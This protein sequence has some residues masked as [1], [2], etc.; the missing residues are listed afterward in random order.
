MPLTS[1]GTGLIFGGQT[2]A[3]ASYIVESETD[4]ES[5]VGSEDTFNADG[6]LANRAVYYRWPKRTFTLI[7]KTGAV[8]TTDFPP[9]NKCAAT[10]AFADWWVESAPRQLTKSPNRIT[11]TLVSIGIS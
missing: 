8:P 7:A 4:N 10:G 9:G 1:V 11:V 6:S 3:F 5:E 2:T